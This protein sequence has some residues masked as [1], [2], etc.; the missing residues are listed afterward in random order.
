MGEV[1]GDWFGEGEGG[2]GEG[3]YSRDPG[4]YDY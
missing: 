2:G 4:L 3:G 1:L